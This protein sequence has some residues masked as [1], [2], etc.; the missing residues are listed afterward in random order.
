MSE[1]EAFKK[2]YNIAKKYK[3]EVK[4]LN[5]TGTYDDPIDADMVKTKKA[6][7]YEEV[8]EVLYEW[9]KRNKE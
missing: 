4:V 7:F 2:I 6:M 5:S 3:K 9:K 8:I 1:K